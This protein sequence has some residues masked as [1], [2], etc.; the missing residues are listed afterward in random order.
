MP[1][2]TDLRESPPRV[3][4]VSEGAHRPARET[5]DRPG[6][7]TL[8]PT[9][10]AARKAPEGPC[11]DSYTIL[12]LYCPGDPIGPHTAPEGPSWRYRVSTTAVD[13]RTR[14]GISTWPSSCGLLTPRAASESTGK[15]SVGG[16]V[17][18]ADPR[19]SVPTSHRTSFGT[20]SPTSTPGSRRTAALPVSHVATTDGEASP[21]RRTDRPGRAPISEALIVPRYTPTNIVN[22]LTG[23]AA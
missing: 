17:P 12:A 4:S 21:G 5:G 9:P 18:D 1:Y 20:T 15:P 10:D 22:G 7:L 2:V 19:G 14:E 3:I 6:V 11:S 13:T 23:D 16:G 8:D